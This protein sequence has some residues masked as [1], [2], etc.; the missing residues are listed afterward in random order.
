MLVFLVRIS[1]I[2]GF[3]PVLLIFYLFLSRFLIK[4]TIKIAHHCLLWT[5]DCEKIVFMLQNHYFHKIYTVS[6]I[7]KT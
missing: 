1:V 5:E 7:F 3:K 4:T 6:V 2:R